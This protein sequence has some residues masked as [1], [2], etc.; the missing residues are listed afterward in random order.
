MRISQWFWVFN[1]ILSAPVLRLD[2]IVEG[3]G[4]GGME[5]TD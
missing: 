1:D 2:S 5:L 3:L 4:E